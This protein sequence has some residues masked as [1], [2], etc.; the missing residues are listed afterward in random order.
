MA[1]TMVRLDRALV[2]PEWLI[3]FPEASVTNLQ[4]TYSDHSPIIV[5]LNGNNMINMNIK[6]K[7]FRFL[8]SWLEH[9]DCD[10]VIDRFWNQSD[11]LGTNLSIYTVNIQKWNKEVFG[12]IFAN[13]RMLKNIIRGIQI[14]QQNQFSHN[15]D[16]LEK[17]F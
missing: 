13:K 10:N 4:R 15:L 7:P 8:A 12:N 11:S 9:P 6:V 3:Q 16:L 5:Q 1:N 2:N 17:S 14:A